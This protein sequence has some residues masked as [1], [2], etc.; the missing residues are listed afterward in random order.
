MSRNFLKIPTFVRFLNYFLTFLK[1]N[2]S[3]S[4]DWLGFSLLSENISIVVPL[5][6]LNGSIIS[7]VGKISVEIMEPF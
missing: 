6:K 1:Q 3:K 4:L 5:K 2:L 7:V